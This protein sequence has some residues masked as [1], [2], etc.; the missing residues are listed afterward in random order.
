MHMSVTAN[1]IINEEL[2]KLKDVIA[3]NM[4]AQGLNA[5]G[6][7]SKS[8]EVVMGD[9]GGALMGRSFFAVLETGRKAGKVPKN[10]RQIIEKWATDKGLTFETPAKLRSFSYLVAR[11]IAAEGTKQYRTGRR[12]DV[13]TDAVNETVTSIQNQLG[14]T[15]LKEIVTINDINEQYI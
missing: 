5:S 4:Q 6:K 12:T 7:T 13:F 15:V 14:S 3:A 8:L 9:N 1:F 10:F 11:K 2:L